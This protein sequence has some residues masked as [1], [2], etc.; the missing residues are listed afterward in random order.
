VFSNPRVQ[1]ELL[2]KEGIR[3]GMTRIQ[4]SG[5]ILPVYEA[6]LR[7][8]SEGV[9]LIIF[10]GK[11]YGTG[12]S[13]DWGAKGPVLLGV[14]AVV[15]ES[16]ERIHRSNLVG[17]GIYPLQFTEGMSRRDLNLDG[18]EQ[19]DL[20]GLSDNVGLR[21]TI[22]LRIR[23]PERGTREV[24][25]LLR[26]ETETER[27]QLQHGGLLKY[28]LRDLFGRG[29]RPEGEQGPLPGDQN[30]EDRDEKTL[31]AGFSSDGPK[32]ATFAGED[33]KVEEADEESFPASDAPATTGV[34]GMGKRKRAEDVS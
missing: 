33:E 15:A 3:G 20:I 32:S 4:P 24:K 31:A 17:M 19:F 9:P 10:A 18:T 12:S 14:R 16:Y 29:S 13:R 30:A 5:E 26:V 27:E 6:A 7:Y 11:E 25:L 23:H 8:K 1:N 34:L 21:P 2:Q 28:V 22:T